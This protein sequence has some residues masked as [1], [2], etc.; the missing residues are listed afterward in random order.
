M[1]NFNINKN[2]CKAAVIVS[3]VLFLNACEMI[4]SQLKHDRAG[5]LDGSDYRRAM[6]PRELPAEDLNAG[7]PE[8][9]THVADATGETESMPLVS[10][11]V[12]QTVPLR[13]ILFE[14]SEQAGIDLELDP[15]ISGSIV[16]TARNRPFD[17]IIDRISNMAGLRYKYQN[18]L[19]RVELDRPYLK[20][21][22]IDY[23]NLT[24]SIES[25]ISVDVS[26]VSGEGADVGS[27]SG[28]D[29]SM[30]TDFWT[31]LE[32]TLESILAAT[33]NYT[34]LSTL[35][36]PIAQ[37]RVSQG[38]DAEDP[39]A[40]P[41]L[42]VQP[43]VVLAAGGASE[44]G[45]SQFS[46]NRSS[47]LISVFTSARQQE[48]IR[49]YLEK[50]RKAVTT[51]VLV[52]AKILEVSLLDEF[53]AGI[54]WG[55]ADGSGINLTGLL[56]FNASL[57]QPSFSPTLNPGNVFTAAL[58]PGNDIQ[59]AV[60]AI[61]R[62]GT[63]KALSSPRITVLNNQAAVLNVV[64]NRVFFDVDVDVEEDDDDGSSTITVDSDV[65]SVPEGILLSVIP[66]VNTDTDEI[67]MFL[68]PTITRV[69]GSI[70]D[71]GVAITIA[72]L[73][74][75]T[76]AALS[77][78]QNLIPEL[79]VQEMD[80]IIKMQSGQ[81]V[82]MGGLMT[83]RTDVET[84]GVPVVSD[85]PVLGNFFRSK[86]DRVQKNELVIFIKSTILPGSNIQQ[87]DKD[88]YNTFGSDRRPFKL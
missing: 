71:P 70:A 29:T 76:A 19:L 46:I 61:S 68:R 86:G 64:E 55:A 54:N 51:Q 44:E 5:G 27:A 9:A 43:G 37:P 63:V 81:V 14:L 45:A 56:N 8:L 84:V 25:S 23:V 65:Q 42:T 39:N 26:V 7:I 13:D 82:V 62:F 50:L 79:A 40:P 35:S 2:L 20:N 15:Q 73:P 87:T 36:N 41:S 83:D 77:G 78:I 3:S 52:E 88:L 11:S 38:G 48:I 72:A 80:S 74:S 16:F 57:A 28:V 59:A 69:V 32:A 17:E 1:I 75:A 22:R 34:P 33:D 21:Y 31:E 60:S 58:N 67:S 66:S 12:N 53:S 49:D 47:G 10:I 18:G 85:L 24:R 30:S 6:A 4:E